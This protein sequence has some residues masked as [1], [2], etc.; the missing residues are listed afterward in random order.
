DLV[1]QRPEIEAAQRAHDERYGKHAERR[2][3]RCRCAVGWKED[4]PDRAGHVTV[5]AEIEPFQRVAHAGGGNS[6]FDVRF[7]DNMLFGWINRCSLHH[8]TLLT[9]IHATVS[10]AN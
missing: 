8:G 3:Q 5:N 1:A 10:T 6:P 9:V 4:M 7:F 2:Q